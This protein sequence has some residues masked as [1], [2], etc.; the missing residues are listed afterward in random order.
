MFRLVCLMYKYIIKKITEQD[1]IRE[2]ILVPKEQGIDKHFCGQFVTLYL[3]EDAGNDKLWDVTRAYSIASPPEEY[4]ML[5][6]EIKLQGVFTHKLWECK[7]GDILGVDG[8]F[9]IHDLSSLPDKPLVMFAGGIGITPMICY[10]RH[11]ILNNNDRKI[12]LFH[13]CRTRSSNINYEELKGIADNNPNI[14]VVFVFTRDNDAPGE[15]RRIDSEMIKKYVTDFKQNAYF[16]CG[17]K[18]FSES[19]ENILL[20]FGVEKTNIVTEAW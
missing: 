7:E 18:G 6:L 14:K 12:L 16:I 10:I 4:P 8:P 19:I 5:R 20:S 17:S 9:G 13:S 1:D 2:F 11:L 15:H 3:F